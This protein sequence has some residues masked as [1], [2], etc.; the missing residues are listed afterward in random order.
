MERRSR[1]FRELPLHLMIIPSVIVALIYSYGPML[2]SVMAFQ[3]FNPVKGIFG[4]QW[5]G[6]KN[7]QYI[8][9]IPGSF[10]VLWNT[11]YIAFFKIIGMI[12]VPVTFA[13]LLNEVQSRYFK[14]TI[15]TMIYLPH[16]LSWIILSGTLIDILSPSEGIVNQIISMMGFEPIFFLGDKFWFPITIILTDIWKGVG[17]GTII[18]LAAITGIDPALYESAIIDG[19]SRW[20][21]TLFITLPGIMPIIVLMTVLS[22]GNILNAG[23]DQV[24]NLYSPQVYDTGDIIDTFVYR[25]GIEQQ[26]YAAATAVGLFKSLV[27][28]IFVSL[29]YL[30]ADKFANYRVF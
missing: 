19:A 8:A 27:S 18:Y 23:F 25:L 6:F 26:Q 4:S 28:F 16:F 24:F 20:K 15:Q 14:R 7:F 13:L 10:I 1:F 30:F 3:D 17:F 29:S 9:N 2:G 11:V 21:Q 22:L 12:I 5:V